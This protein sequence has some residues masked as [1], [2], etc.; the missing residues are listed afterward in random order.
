M[1]FDDCEFNFDESNSKKGPNMEEVLNNVNEKSVDFDFD[2]FDPVE[3]KNN[4]IKS[5]TSDLFNQ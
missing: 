3:E 4:D 5:S 2:Y 1:D